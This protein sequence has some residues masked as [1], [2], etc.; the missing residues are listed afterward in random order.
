MKLPHRMYTTWF[1]FGQPS[2]SEIMP[3]FYHHSVEPTI[4]HLFIAGDDP[5]KL[6]LS[7]I[8]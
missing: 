3:T 7:P 8:Y 1:D 4:L 6:I 2:D 5:N